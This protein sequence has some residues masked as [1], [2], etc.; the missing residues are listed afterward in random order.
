MKPQIVEV[1][2][3]RHTRFPGLKKE[4]PGGHNH[5]ETNPLILTL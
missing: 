2:G 1:V 4:S 3:T 5:H